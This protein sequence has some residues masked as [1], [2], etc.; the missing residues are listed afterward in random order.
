M[1]N[2][3]NLSPTNPEVIVLFGASGDL[4]RKM[5]LPALYRLDEGGR[6]QQRIIGV[7]LDDWTDVRFRRHAEASLEAAPDEVEPKARDRF[8]DRLSYLSGDYTDPSTFR[9]L[10]GIVGEGRPCLHYLAVPPSLFQRVVTGLAGA[11]L[12]E[13]SRVVVEKPFGRDLASARDLNRVLHRVLPERSIYRIDHFLGKESVESLL[14]FRY[15]N[16][17]FEAVWNKDHVDH[18]EVTLAEAFGVDGR[19]SLYDSL[20]VVRDVIQN[21]LLQVVCLLAMEAPPSSSAASFADERARILSAVR[22]VEP[23]QVLYGQYAGYRQ[24]T[25]VDPNSSV[26]TF[27]ALRLEI[28]TPRWRGVPFY[29]RAGKAMATTATEAVV[30]FKE[31]G[32][33]PFSSRDSRPESDRLVFRVGPPTDGVDLMV[34]TK[35]PGEELLLAPTSLS[36]DYEHAFGH[37]PLA[38]ERLLQ[39]ALEGDRVNFARED[40]V[41]EAWRIV[42]AV[43][44]P[45]S[46]PVAYPVGSWGPSASLTFLHGGRP[47]HQP[48][49]PLAGTSSTTINHRSEGGIMSELQPERPRDVGVAERTPD[50]SHIEGAEL[51]ANESRATLRPLGFT[52]EEVNE[53]ALTYIAE[54]AS[55]DVASF[56]AWIREKEDSPA[57][58]TRQHGGV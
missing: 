49:G 40:A 25:G 52:D 45:S 53:W 5:V 13:K 22:P 41:E 19:G 55:G 39:E 48:G 28:E 7:A 2:V 24:V 50:Q 51:L 29:I 3:S 17:I 21:H 11:G 46:A 35:L 18:V 15:A 34:Q 6:L 26:P 57:R 12:L 38:Y 23:T 1:V 32:P 44:D 30:V 14:T 36:V 54:M 58:P 4:A 37:L 42:S 43:T 47:W 27:A 56:L 10:A 33:L 20:G 9:R 31:A 8:L 16:P